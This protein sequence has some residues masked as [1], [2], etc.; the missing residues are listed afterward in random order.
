MILLL[1]LLFLVASLM[2]ANE[3]SVAVNVQHTAYCMGE[4]CKLKLRPCFE[5]L[6]S[7][8]ILTSL[9]RTLGDK[10]DMQ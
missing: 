8:Q 7:S 2:L 1:F 5:V 10:L 6:S 9:V 4:K 3:T